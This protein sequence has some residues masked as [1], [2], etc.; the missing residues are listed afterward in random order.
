MKQGFLFCSFLRPFA[1]V[2]HDSTGSF[3]LCESTKILTES[4]SQRL[5]AQELDERGS[6]GVGGGR[7]GFG[8]EG[9]GVVGEQAGVE[10]LVVVS[11]GRERNQEGRQSRAREFGQRS[12]SRSRDD[13]GGAAVLLGHV[14][15]EGLHVGRQRQR[16]ITLTNRVEIGGSGLMHDSPTGKLGAQSCENSDRSQAL[17]GFGIGLS[18]TSVLNQQHLPIPKFRSA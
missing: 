12:R 18:K 17:R 7:G 9:G 5:V 11:R 16:G 4:V 8:H 15:K 10:T 1:E 3:R 2:V 6:Q 13:A 14:A